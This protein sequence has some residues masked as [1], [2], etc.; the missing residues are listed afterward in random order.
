MISGIELR[1]RKEKGKNKK[2]DK[3]ENV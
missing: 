1:E 3:K 2:K